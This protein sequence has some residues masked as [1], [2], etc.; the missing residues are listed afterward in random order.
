MNVTAANTDRIRLL[1]LAVVAACAGALA[2]A[3]AS[4]HLFGLDPCLLCHYQRAA[5]AAAGGLA[6]VGV[7][8][9]GGGR[10][11][12]VALSAVA[13]LAGAGTA[14]YHVGVEQHW[15]EQTAACAGRPAGQSGLSVAELRQQMLAPPPKACDE[16]DW[17]L[18]GIS[19][20]GFNVLASLALAGACAAGVGALWKASSRVREA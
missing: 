14:F 2:V 3:F 12:M 1:P 9:R 17:S 18:F 16:V 15:W 11:L 5:Y 7:F 4:E 20:A 19:L 10:A 8:V 13:F 6:M